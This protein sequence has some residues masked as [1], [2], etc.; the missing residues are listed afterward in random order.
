MVVLQGWRVRAGGT[1]WKLSTAPERNRAK[2]RI[3]LDAGGPAEVRELDFGG[4][5]VCKMMELFFLGAVWEWKGTAR[6]IRG[7]VLSPAAHGGSQARGRIRDVA[8]SLR[9]RP[10]PQQ[11]GIQAVPVTHTTAHGKAGSLTH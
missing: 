9:P 8:T 6:S 7:W 11:R 2:R 1:G 10:E 3:A 5:S 4:A